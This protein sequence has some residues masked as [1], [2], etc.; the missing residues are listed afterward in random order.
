MENY[1]LTPASHAGTTA[2]ED[3]SV[4]DTRIGR[5]VDHQT[6]IVAGRRIVY[7]G[8]ADGAKAPPTARRISG[9]GKYLMP[10]LWDMHA[11]T[12]ALSPQLHFPLLVANG[13]TSIR[14]MGDGCSWS[15]DLD[16]VPKAPQWKAGFAQGNLLAPRLVAT[17]SYHV[18][19]L[20]D[21]DDVAQDH[22]AESKRLVGA[23]KTRGDEF[24][25]LQLDPQ[26]TPAVFH[27]LSAAASEQGM[28]VAGHLPYSIDLLDP[29]L[30]GLGSIE[31]DSGL[32]PQCASA[33]AS[34]DGRDRSKLALLASLDQQRC[35]ALLAALAAR[36]T[37]YVPT[38]V[39]SIGQDY[40]LL[41]E[42]YRNNPR[43]KYVVSMQRWMWQA[44][45]A[46]S[47]AGTEAAD[48]SALEAY[49]R[50]SLALTRQAK[51]A[52]V[53]VMAGSDALDAYVVHGFG[54]H[55]EL[56]Q[57][58]LA[59]LSPAEALRS[60]TWTPAVHAGLSD[61]LGSV[62]S[63]QLADLVLVAHNPLLD[64][65]HARDIEVVVLDGRVHQR[66]DLDGMLRYVQRQASS[67]TACKFFWGMIGPA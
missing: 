49:Y 17:A 51:T 23:L 2:I 39:A 22:R 62:Q 42:H 13:V 15:D 43:L 53:P 44:Y 32:L 24:I 46:L 54:L 55:D 35:T 52:G 7:A 11:H 40:F 6:V 19:T 28:T 31:H 65:R 57:L 59:G 50:A 64:I 37:G 29:A 3:V 34:F 60:A 5:I 4:V 10:G 48:R 45:G 41:D 16:C 36:G 1:P 14:D 27:A 61:Q 12:L 47:V 8:P 67:A 56:E 9:R 30:A 26:I 63:G 18:E 21:P 38:H 33:R 25:K 66:S 58:V 20:G